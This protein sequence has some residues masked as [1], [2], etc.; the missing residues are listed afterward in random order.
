MR[1]LCVDID[2][3]RLLCVD[4]DRVRLYSASSPFVL[5]LMQCLFRYFQGSP[6]EQGDLKRV[7]LE[8]ASM[9]FVLADGTAATPD[10]ASI[11]QTPKYRH[12]VSQVSTSWCWSAEVIQHLHTFLVFRV[13][14]PSCETWCH[15]QED[16]SNILRAMNI[17]RAAS[18]LRMRVMILKPVTPLSLSL[19]QLQ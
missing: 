5:V 17:H 3:V 1:L 7:K 8:H 16:R 9:A 19:S 15:L 14:L 6:M 10:K 4:I 18:Q 2:R 13:M 12:Q 11:F